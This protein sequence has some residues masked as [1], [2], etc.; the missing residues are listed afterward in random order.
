MKKYAVR[1]YLLGMSILAFSTVVKSESA[2]LTILNDVRPHSVIEVQW[3][4]PNNERDQ[5]VLMDAAGNEGSA[6]YTRAGNPVG[7][8]VENTQSLIN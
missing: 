4:G 7:I 5:I 8:G 2:T 1:S 3:H 6:Q